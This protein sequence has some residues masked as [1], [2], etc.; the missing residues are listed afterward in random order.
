MD[1]AKVAA[2]LATNGGRVQDYE[3]VI[4]TVAA[5]PPLIC[6]PTTCGTGS[7]VTFSALVARGDGMKIPIIGKALR[8]P[9]AVLDPTLLATLPPDVAAASAVDAICHATESFLNLLANPFCDALDRHAL[10]LLAPCLQA[11]TVGGDPSARERLLV[12]A[13]LAGIAI[14]ANAANLC[15]AMSYPITARYRIPHGV[16]V[17]ILLPSVLAFNEGAQPERE[18][19]VASLLGAPGVPVAEAVAELFASV[20]IPTDLRATLA[21]Q[22]DVPTLVA[23]TMPSRNVALN[24][25]PVSKDDVGALFRSLITA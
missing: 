15:H 14:S 4:E 8:P 21:T 17:G 11:G 3:G 6:V 12:G 24:P 1:C 5:L 7:E 23:Q 2:L 19:E 20:G 25:R 9:L 13:N 22:E 18:R 16:A 10:A